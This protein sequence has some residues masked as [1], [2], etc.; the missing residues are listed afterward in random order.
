M[1]TPAPKSNVIPFPKRETA[2]ERKKREE[3]ELEAEILAK[4]LERA[5]KL[6]W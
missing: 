2:E 1:E 5:S 6:G 3:K 4:I